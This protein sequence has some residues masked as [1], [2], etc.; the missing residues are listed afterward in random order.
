MPITTVS[1]TAGIAMTVVESI[2]S[3]GGCSAHEKRVA[4]IASRLF[5][6]VQPIHGLKR[7]DRRLLRIAALLQKQLPFCSRCVM[8][9][10]PP[11]PLA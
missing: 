3:L 10:R 8:S 5:D 2:R 4:R 1:R 11:K 9:A 7:S 6:V